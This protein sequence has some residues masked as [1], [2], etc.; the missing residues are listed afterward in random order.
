MIGFKN[1][2]FTGEPEVT[3]LSIADADEQPILPSHEDLN[4][5]MDLES[6]RQ[7]MVSN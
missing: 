6:Q 1:G 3:F 7:T 2:T 5:P 4:R